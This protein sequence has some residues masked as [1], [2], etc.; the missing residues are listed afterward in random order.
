[1]TRSFNAATTINSR[2]TTSLGLRSVRAAA[3]YGIATPAR[4]LNTS[5]ARYSDATTVLD[6][7]NMNKS[8]VY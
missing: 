4:P 1:M 5:A 8:P 7:V 6:K 3:L 2:T